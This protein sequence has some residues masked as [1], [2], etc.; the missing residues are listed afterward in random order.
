MKAETLDW[1]VVGPLTEEDMAALTAEAEAEWSA[2]ERGQEKP[3]GGGNGPLVKMFAEQLT[4][5]QQASA[6]PAPAKTEEG[7]AELSRVRNPSGIV[8]SLDNAVMAIRKLGVVFRFDEFR[9][10]VICEG[11]EGRLGVTMEDI[12]LH[13]RRAVI[14]TLGFDPEPTHT[15]DAIRLLAQENSFNPVLDYIDAPQWDGVSRIDTWV[16]VYLGAEDNELNRAFGRA[17]LIAGVRRARR[18]GCKFDCVLV[19]EGPQGRGKSS[20][21]KIMAGGEDFFSDE[22]VIGVSYKEQQELL[23]GKWIVELPELAGLARAEIR[24]VK[25]FVSKQYDRARGAFQRSV[26]EMPRRCIF[27]GTTN[28]SQYLRDVTGNRRFWP[29]TVGK[30][31]LKGLAEDMPQLWA[32]AAMA[33]REAPDPISIPERLWAAAEE[34]QAERVAGDPWEDVLLSALP[35]YAKVAEGEL[36]ISTQTVFEK[37]MNIDMRQ[38]RMADYRRLGDCMRKLGWS[39]PKVL[40]LDGANVKGLE[41]GS[42]VERVIWLLRALPV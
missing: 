12:V 13:V 16:S 25:Q 28:D 1:E 29:V 42:E 32:E 27:V 39:G 41:S 21:L 38:A 19:L 22:I 17:V 9:Q 20:V 5:K 30:I 8:A 36:R 34:R 35:A 18:P 6:V 40:R 7:S 26:E 3:T 31:D 23:Q 33:E 11:L 14:Q 24:G 4:R 15:R 2:F 10:K 37:I